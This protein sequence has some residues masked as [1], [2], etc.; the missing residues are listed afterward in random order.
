MTGLQEPS[1]R[2][3]SFRAHSMACIDP[4]SHWMIPAIDLTR[5]IENYQFQAYT[6]LSGQ[7]PA[8]LVPSDTG[9]WQ[10]VVLGFTVVCD[11]GGPEL[12]GED[13]IRDKKTQLKTSVI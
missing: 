11:T 1:I 3:A 7:N 12:Y 9:T 8:D 5:G 2:S 10:G 13:N 4:F 6:C